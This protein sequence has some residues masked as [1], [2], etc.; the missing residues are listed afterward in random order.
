MALFKQANEKNSSEKR[1][2]RNIIMTVDNFM[3]LQRKK[4]NEW[5]EKR[6][7]RKISGA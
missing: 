4:A 6:E 7:K 2:E 3:L 1:T 5:N